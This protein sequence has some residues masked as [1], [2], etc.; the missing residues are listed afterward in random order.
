MS[1]IEPPKDD[2]S[3]PKLDFRHSRFSLGD[4]IKEH[5][6]LI[7]IAVSALAVIVSFL[8]LD[9]LQRNAVQGMI[10]ARE[11]SMR[12]DMRR[13]DDRIRSLETR[14]QSC[15]CHLPEGTEKDVGLLNER[16]S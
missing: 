16:Q 11:E 6:T 10:Q 9:T 14:R 4:W 12:T 8:V 15:T 3:A 13:L 2:Q 5:S 7:T 1:Q